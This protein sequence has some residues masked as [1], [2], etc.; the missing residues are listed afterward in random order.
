VD[1]RPTRS[2]TI[3]GKVLF[4]HEPDVVAANPFRAMLILA[5]R[6]MRESKT[7]MLRRVWPFPKL[8]PLMG[9]WQLQ[10]FLLGVALATSGMYWLLRGNTNPT[11]QF[12]FTFI[13]GNLTWL[14]VT[15]SAPALL[16]LRPPWDSFAYLAVLLPVAAVASSMS[17]VASRLVVGRTPLC[18]HQ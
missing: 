2:C 4:G 15:L 9:F 13:I 16:K 8:T 14:A 10:L 18:Q 6:A 17:T 3:F 11:Q 12:L 5:I 7:F 1:H